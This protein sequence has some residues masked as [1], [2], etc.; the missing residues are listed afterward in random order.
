MRRIIAGAFMSLDGVMQAPGGPQ[1]DTTGGF[2]FGGWTV[3]YLDEQVASALEDEFG[4]EFD[5]LLGRRTYDIFAAYWPN[6]DAA[7]ADALN[8]RIARAFNAATKYVA[9]HRPESLTWSHSQALGNDVPAAVRK[10]KGE[11]GKTLLVQG[12]SELLHQLMAEGLVDE[13]R[14]FVYPTV[15]GRGKRLFADD[16]RSSEFK[17]VMGSVSSRGVLMGTY[18][19]GGEVKTGSFELTDA[20][21]ARPKGRGSR[22]EEAPAPSHP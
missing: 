22:P 14:L 18:E 7:S 9:T 13:L 1:E 6:L 3:P 16:A 4:A 19:R 11:P 21:R 12:S 2:R 10:L 5:L 20:E 17:M 8:A 15:L